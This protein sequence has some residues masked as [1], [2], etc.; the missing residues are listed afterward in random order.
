MSVGAREKDCERIADNLKSKY[1]AS[2]LR[3][4]KE[5][6]GNLKANNAN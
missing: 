1:T 3:E 6:Q 2:L 5:L 4:D